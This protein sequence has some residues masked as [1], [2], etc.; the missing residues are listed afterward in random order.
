M[1]KEMELE[2]GGR[3]DCTLR[4]WRQ[5]DASALAAFSNN[6]KLA[7]NMTDSFPH[8]YRLTDAEDFIKGS[9]AYILE[10]YSV[11]FL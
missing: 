2:R 5:E 11:P 1:I 8:P 3:M 6:E 10:S 7:A 4:K 9:I